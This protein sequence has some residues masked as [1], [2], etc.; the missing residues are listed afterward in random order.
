MHPNERA[1]PPR[2]VV[3]RLVGIGH[4]SQQLDQIAIFN[5]PIFIDG[6]GEIIGKLPYR[7][8]IHARQLGAAVGVPINIH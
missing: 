1:T 4:R 2:R 3:H 7:S 8:S 6:H 5:A